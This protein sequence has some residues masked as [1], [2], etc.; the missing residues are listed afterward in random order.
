MPGARD[1]EPADCR[2]RKSMQ[3]NLMSTFG[4]QIYET[5]CRITSMSTFQS[6]NI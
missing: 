3:D 1:I 6:T 5:L 4:R 2:R